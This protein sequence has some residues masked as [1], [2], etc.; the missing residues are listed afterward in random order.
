ME[1]RNGLLLVFRQNLRLMCRPLV[2]GGIACNRG[3][4]SNP[5]LNERS[6]AGTAGCGQ[7]IQSE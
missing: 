5:A 6:E 7:R 3:I 1:G 2:E 4:A